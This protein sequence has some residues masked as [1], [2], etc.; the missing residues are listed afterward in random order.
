MKR[1]RDIISQMSPVRLMSLVG[2]ISLVGL[3]GCTRDEVPEMS[4]NTPQTMTIIASQS[5]FLEVNPWS[6]R[7]LPSGYVSYNE[8]YPQTTPPNTTIGV[9]MTPERADAYVDFIYQGYENG[10]PTN[11]WK[12]LVAITDQQQYYIY[13]FMPKEDAQNV[14]IT[15]LNGRAFNAADVDWS[16]GAIMNLTMNTVTAADVCV[17]VGVKKYETNTPGVTPP[18][19]G[20][21]G[22]QLGQFGYAGGPRGT[23]FVYLLLKHIYSGVH[24]KMSLD[25]TYASLR[26][27]KVTGM[28]LQAE[29]AFAQTINMQVTLTANNTNTDPVTVTAPTSVG[30]STATATL[31]PWAGGPTEMVVPTSPSFS[32]HVG[33]FAPNTCKNFTLR[34]TFDVY[35]KEGNL[36]RKG[37]VA[38][39][40]ISLAAADLAAGEVY[41]VN[42]TIRPTYLYVLSD[43]DLENPTITQ[44]TNP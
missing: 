18:P 33:C 17:I 25:P 23:N 43:P 20:D 31:F 8:L 3:M 19:I 41:T 15:D 13:G 10:V 44:S 42:L 28:E 11:K 1:I 27:V 36:T 14:T 9:F 21:S 29:D 30:S 24:F 37:A 6:T 39:N 38:E 4:E 26:T 16:S 5:S 12:S 7:A 2:L 34:I 35:D 32:D 22:I 40:K